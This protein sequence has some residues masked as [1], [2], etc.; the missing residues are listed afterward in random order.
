MKFT[1]YAQIFEQR[2]LISY[3]G[4][5]IIKMIIINSMHACT[6]IDLAMEFFAHCFGYRT[7]YFQANCTIYDQ[8]SYVI[9]AQCNA[10]STSRY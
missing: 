8:T 7:Y 1:L 6:S 4:V 9:H 5:V 10:S 3:I 2:T